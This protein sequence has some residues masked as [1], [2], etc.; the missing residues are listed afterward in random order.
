[1]VTT[2]RNPLPVTAEARPS[3]VTLRLLAGAAEIAGSRTV[4]LPVKG[5]LTVRDAFE[6][7]CDRFPAFREMEGR[8]LFAANAEYAASE[9]YLYPGDELAIIPPVSGGAPS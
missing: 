4:L 5:P 9:C 3:A 6:L 8:L 2:S 7:L 1:V